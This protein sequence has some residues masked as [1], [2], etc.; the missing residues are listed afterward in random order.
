MLVAYVALAL[1]LEKQP[2]VYQEILRA[3]QEHTLKSK[4]WVQGQDAR[5]LMR[6][7]EQDLDHVEG[8]VRT[9]EAYVTSEAFKVN[10]EFRNL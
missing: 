5:G 4:P 10:R 2:V 7:L 6:T 9:M 1:M 8:K 3:K